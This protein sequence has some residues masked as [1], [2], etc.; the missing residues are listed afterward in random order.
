MVV[1][2]IEALLSAADTVAVPPFSEI[3]LS[4]S[5]SD[6]V[7]ASSSSV[8]VPVPIPTF[9]PIIALDGLLSFTTMVSFC[10][11]TVSPAIVTLISFSVSPTANVNVLPVNAV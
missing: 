1:G 3:E 5:E 7:G 9:V 11:S 2:S 10:S 4:S 6:T 8:I